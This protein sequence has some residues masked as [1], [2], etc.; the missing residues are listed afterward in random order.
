MAGRYEKKLVDGQAIKERFY[1]V[2]AAGQAQCAA[3]VEFY[4]ARGRVLGLEGA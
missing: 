1:T 2:T 4:A 3:A